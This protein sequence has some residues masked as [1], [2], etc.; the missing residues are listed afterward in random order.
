[1][2]V[3]IL[4]LLVV[5]WQVALLACIGVLLSFLTIQLLENKSKKN[6]PTYHY[7]QNQLIEKVVE[8]IR[9]IQVIKSFS[10]ENASLR[11]FNRAVNESKRVNTKIEM[12]YIPF[13]LLHL[14]SLKVTSILIVL[15]ACLLFIHNSI[16]LPT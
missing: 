6:A 14:L 2:S 5:S 11:S 1:I 16:D 9:G 7:A 8:V 4:S 12:Q 13:N 15:V 10:K 3:L